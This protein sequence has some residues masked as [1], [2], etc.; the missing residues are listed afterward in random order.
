[1]ASA[2]GQKGLDRLAG[3][4]LMTNEETVARTAIVALAQQLGQGQFAS[5]VCPLCE[6]GD[7]KERTLSLAVEQNGIVKFNCF[8]AS[9]GFSGQAYIGP[10]PSAQRE[11]PTTRSPTNFLTADLHKLSEDEISWF[12]TRFNLPKS[13]IVD[14]I[15]RTDARY[16][17]PIRAPNGGSTRGWITRRPWEGSPADTKANRNHYQW[18]QKALTY[19]E[20]DEPVMSWYGNNTGKSETYLVEDQ[21]SAMRLASWLDGAESPARVVALM[22][23]GINYSKIAEI[24][25]ST[26]FNTRVVF[27]L[28]KDATGHAF[29]LARKY[30]QGFTSCRVVVL[31][32]DIKDSSDDELMELPL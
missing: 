24:Q 2:W 30:G 11:N 7:S 17:L 26:K 12:Q 5:Q 15:F 25:A 29:A 4:T 8:R 10:N 1:M 32:K 23:T 14:N 19:M 9:C 28:D 16:A 22:G 18:A 20:K 21:I 6:G 31:S 3:Q 13:L 27:A